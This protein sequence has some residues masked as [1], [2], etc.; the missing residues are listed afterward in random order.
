MCS[1][2]PNA[3][4]ETHED[5]E[6]I[7]AGCKRR[8]LSGID[9]IVKGVKDLSISD[10]IENIDKGKLDGTFKDAKSEDTI[11]KDLN[12][13][14]DDFAS[15]TGQNPN[16]GEMSEKD[17][18]KM[19]DFFGMMTK[20]ESKSYIGNMFRKEFP[21][22]S[23]QQESLKDMTP[24]QLE[25]FRKDW[26]KGH[27][28]KL[29]CKKVQNTSWGR[30]DKTKGTYRTV[31]NMVRHFGGWEC[32]DAVK[33]A[34]TVASKCTGLGHP[35]IKRHSQS[36]L[37]EF[38]LLE[39]QFEETF[40]TSW[41][42]F[43]EEIL[44]DGSS[45][46][47]DSG[48]T[49]V[50][51]NRSTSTAGEP[52]V[53]AKA[54]AAAAAKAKGTVAVPKTSPPKPSDKSRVEV[55]TMARETSKVRRDYQSASAQYLDITSNMEEKQEWA[56]AKTSPMIN[57]LKVTWNH[58]ALQVTDVGKEYI[59]ADDI[60]DMRKKYTDARIMDELRR[61]MGMK[62]TIKQLLDI[63]ASMRTITKEMKID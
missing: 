36:E 8:K 35:W 7:L 43:K 12:K 60:A 19:H 10:L 11:I 59:I 29:E 39:S 53:A 52:S 48:G 24:E 41:N 9:N 34:L 25:K 47:N 58:L 63:S 45:I 5:F 3:R 51:P 40:S 15:L 2:M 13:L 27:V 38:L 28:E 26:C 20:W 1:T 18:K 50:D 37:L 55:A 17:K 46:T 22:G 62:D 56:W 30:V 31:G 4:T 21:A 44:K 16:K 54:K 23:P 32:E 6:A 42:M 61:F 14:Q 33:G 57:K 49:L